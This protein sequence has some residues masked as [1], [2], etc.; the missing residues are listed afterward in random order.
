M[1]SVLLKLSIPVVSD[2]SCNSSYKGAI[3]NRMI[4][5]GGEYGKDSCQVRAG[6]GE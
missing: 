4:C 6:L 3:T 5:A 2:A 1:S